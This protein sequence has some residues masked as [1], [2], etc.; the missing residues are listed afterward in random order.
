[1]TTELH[2][3]PLGDQ[4]KRGFD[5]FSGVREEMMDLFQ[6]LRGLA[7]K[8]MELARAELSEQAGY[9]RMSATF[10]AVAALLGLVTLG[11]IAVTSMFLLDLVVP[12]WAAA[13]IT[14]G[15]L[16][17]LT[18]LLAALAYAQLKQLT[19][20]PKKTLHSVNEDMRWARDRMNFSAK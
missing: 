13:L 16:L 2:H 9:A 3:E 12:L 7:Q 5:E 6:D 11:F 15:G 14:T 18:L 8:E 19:V 4:L 20:A 10:G 17:L 1:M